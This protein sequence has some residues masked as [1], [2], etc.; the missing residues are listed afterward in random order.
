[1]AQPNDLMMKLMLTFVAI[2]AM[3]VLR[4]E[5]GMMIT[6]LQSGTLDTNQPVITIMKVVL[7]RWSQRGCCEFSEGPRTNTT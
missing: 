2:I 3:H 7:A 4:P 6:S 1:M 5:K